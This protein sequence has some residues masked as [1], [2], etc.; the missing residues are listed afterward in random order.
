MAYIW[1]ARDIV[2]L[3][4]DPAA[5]PTVLTADE[6]LLFVF[7]LP[8]WLLVCETSIRLITGHS[9]VSRLELSDSIERA[10]WTGASL[11]IHDASGTETAITVAS[12][13]LASIAPGQ[14]KGTNRQS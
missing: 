7:R 11:H 12:T 6:D 10:W 4:D 13:Q 5:E 8:G 9:H 14:A 1:S 2:M 3:P